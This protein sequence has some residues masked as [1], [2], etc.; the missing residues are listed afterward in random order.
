MLKEKNAELFAANGKLNMELNEMKA[1][2]KL[3][4]EQAIKDGTI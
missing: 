1:T 2:N 3:L 4:A